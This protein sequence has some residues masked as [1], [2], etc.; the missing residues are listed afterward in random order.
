M[1]QLTLFC[2]TAG[3]PGSG[4]AF[5]E[6]SVERIELR[7]YQ[8]D[9]VKQVYSCIHAGE[10]RILVVAPT[11][12]GKTV[13]TAKIISDAHSKGRN[14]LFLVHM[15]VLVKQTI[16]KL[17]RFGIKPGVIK[18]GYIEDR[19]APVQIASIQ[20]LSRRKWIDREWLDEALVILDECHTTAFSAA[21]RE[22]FTLSR[23][24]WFLGV[25]ATPWRLSRKEGM[26]DIFD[27]LVLSPLPKELTQMGYLVKPRYFGFGNIDLA[28]VKSKNGDFDE[29]ELAIA[30]D[31]PEQVSHIV[32]QW[33]LLA[34]GRR[35]ICFAVNIRHSLNIRDAF[36]AARIS[37]AH[38]DGST[39]LLQREFIYKQLDK[40]EIQVLVSC[41]A[42]SLGFDVPS[43]EAV[44][45]C[46]PTKSRA[47]YFQQ[48]G[49]GLRVSPHTGKEDVVVLDQG[50][51]VLRHGYVEDL[52]KE[53]FQLIKGRGSNKGEPPPMKKCPEDKGGCGAIV[54]AFFTKCPCCQYQFPSK[55]QSRSDDLI[56]LKPGD[57][58][59][60][61]SVRLS[62]YHKQCKSAY[63]TCK[64]PGYAAVLYKSKY[65]EYPPLEWRR[66]AV[67]GGKNSERLRQDYLFYLKKI[68]LSKCKDDRWIE[69]QMR[70]EF[71]EESA[72]YLPAIEPI[73]SAWERVVQ[74]VSDVPTKALL[75]YQLKPDFSQEN[76]VRLL[77]KTPAFLVL[78]QH[79]KTILVSAI[80]AVFG[81][82]FQLEIELDAK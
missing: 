78:A 61:D 69:E 64:S 51:N 53:D 54:Y 20:T 14:C 67:F 37:S 46:R 28:G 49:R 36:L 27:T 55:K 11:G 71:G 35:T 82:D 26:G 39:P 44:L 38:I 45:L 1:Q 5:F 70:L 76:R 8:R 25:T 50:G 19:S 63:Y 81:E 66:G 75:R 18:A 32:R 17:N 52:S 6:R 68:A 57:D 58:R 22:L 41:Q 43:I 24:A 74:L 72:R 15:D 12:S 47:M 13:L 62:Y 73:H 42:L 3:V 9:T 77:T 33:Q 16:D 31:Q 10:K 59:T 2:E 80:K 34:A 40:G 48:L 23:S 65:G 60:E 30:C 56:E 79:K 7:D 21:A 4:A 29:T